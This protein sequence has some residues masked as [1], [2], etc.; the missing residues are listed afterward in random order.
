MAKPKPNRKPSRLISRA[1]KKVCVLSNS[2]SLRHMGG[3]S[4]PSSSRE[5]SRSWSSSISVAWL[6]SDYST[7]RLQKWQM[8]P[9]LC[10]PTIQA[11]FLLRASNLRSLPHH[12]RREVHSY[13]TPQNC[14]PAK[15]DVIMRL[16]LQIEGMA[17]CDS[18][19]VSIIYYKA[20]D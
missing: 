20:H 15:V 5:P 14:Q 8:L 16:V 10:F 2:Y 7:R 9:L 19:T 4:V 6:R 11:L 12:H 1:K 3:D 17:W 13:P 18:W